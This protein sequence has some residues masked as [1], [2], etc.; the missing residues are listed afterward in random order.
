M[1]RKQPKHPRNSAERVVLK[2]GGFRE[3]ARILGHKHP[4]TVHGWIRRGVIPPR[5]H[6]TIWQAA[7][8][9]KVKLRK[10]D[11]FSQVAA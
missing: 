9:H 10:S 1:S 11:F 5:Q 8:A 7:Q 3:M 4:T 6:E 2:F